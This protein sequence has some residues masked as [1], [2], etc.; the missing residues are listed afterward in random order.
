MR[1]KRYPEEFK[2]EAVK[3]VIDR[4]YTVSD[5]AKRLGV[6]TKSLYAWVKRY[7]EPTSDNKALTAQQAELRQLKA[8]LR[9]VTEER[10]ILK[11][12]AVYF[13]SES[14]RSTRS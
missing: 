3:Q 12:A 4:G 9:R 11:E 1:G 10:D 5:V 2:I 8:Q 13:A 6:T 7:G 14:K